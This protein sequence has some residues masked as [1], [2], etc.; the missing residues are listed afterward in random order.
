[1]ALQILTLRYR[2]RGIAGVK[3]NAKISHVDLSCRF[4]NSKS[5]ENQEHLE[6]C[7]GFGFE[8]RQL[9]LDSLWGKLEFWRRCSVRLATA[10][11]DSSSG[12]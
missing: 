7:G 4:C 11:G 3:T 9:N 12:G 6:V 1:M 5:T 8:R 2:A 10:T